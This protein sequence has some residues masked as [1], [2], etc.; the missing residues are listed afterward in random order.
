VPASADIDI[1]NSYFA[2][3]DEMTEFDWLFI[4]G[5]AGIQTNK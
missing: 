5:V 2:A 3:I 1:F 4:A